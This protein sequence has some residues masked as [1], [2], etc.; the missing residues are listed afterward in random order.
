MTKT[1]L[2][3]SVRSVIGFLFPRCA[4]VSVAGG[5]SLAEH[6]ILGL[7][8]GWLGGFIWRLREDGLVLKTWVQWEYH[9][10]VSGTI[11]CPVSLLTNWQILVKTRRGNWSTPDFHCSKLIL[12]FWTLWDAQAQLK[13]ILEKILKFKYFLPTHGSRKLQ[14]YC[15]QPWKTCCVSRGFESKGFHEAVT[16]FESNTLLFISI[17]ILI[18][19]QV[20]KMFFLLFLG[21]TS[22]FLELILVRGGKREACTSLNKYLHAFLV[23]GDVLFFSRNFPFF[24]FYFLIAIIFSTVENAQRCFGWME[25]SSGLN[26]STFSSTEISLLWKTGL[27]Y[28]TVRL[29]NTSAGSGQPSMHHWHRNLMRFDLEKG[30]ER[31]SCFSS[32]FTNWTCLKRREWKNK[33]IQSLVW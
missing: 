21:Q 1:F 29:P 6:R 10:S 5:Y 31:T 20:L 4:N 14:A 8:Q 32:I 17:F 23:F 11:D 19:V 33:K 26:F 7:V 18:D 12:F 25:Q 24:Y 27:Y 28:V 3:V 22:P 16:R 9:L 2:P 15:K 13:A 30:F